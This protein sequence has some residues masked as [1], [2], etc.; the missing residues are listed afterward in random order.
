MRCLVL[1]LLISGQIFC[2]KHIDTAGYFNINGIKQFIRI[3]GKDRSKPLL[4]ILHG[5]PGGSLMQKTDNMTAK[6]QQHFVVV[7][8]DQRE[9]AETK[10]VNRSTQPLTLQLFYDDTHDLTDTLL[11]RFQQSKLYL[12]GYSWGTVLGFYMADKYPELLYAYIAVSPVIN[13]WV[14]ERF[15]L[16]MMKDQMGKEANKELARVRIPFEDGEQLYYHRKW[17]AKFSGQPLVSITFRKSFVLDWAN[18]WFDVWS[19]SCS[20]N[21]FETIPAVKCPIYFF[22]GKEDYNT[23]H[24]ITQEYFNKISAPK[25]DIFLFNNVGHGLPETDPG[26]FQDIIIN[27]ILPKTYAQ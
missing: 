20:I 24:L 5:G 23:N 6:L 11:A 12:V 16:E 22:A 21:R 18:T 8:W 17:L 9:T 10:R 4:L 1:C 7:Q 26:P 19:A 15:S 27:L 13:Q 2:Q 3:K 14:S 25:K